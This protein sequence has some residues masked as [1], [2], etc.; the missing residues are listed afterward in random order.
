MALE[1]GR[2]LDMVVEG[3]KV[4]E[5]VKLVVGMVES[6]YEVELHTNSNSSCQMK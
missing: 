4:G 1:V 6:H 5:M 2:M 3:R